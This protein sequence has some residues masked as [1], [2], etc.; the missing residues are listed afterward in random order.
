M[1]CVEGHWFI[2]GSSLLRCGGCHAPLGM[3]WCAE[4]NALVHEFHRKVHLLATGAI[5]PIPIFATILF[6]FLLQL[7][8]DT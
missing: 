1:R 2:A 4:G 8:P 5:T 3:L 6:L 7:S